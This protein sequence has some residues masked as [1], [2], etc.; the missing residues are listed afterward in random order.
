MKHKVEIFDIWQY[1]CGQLFN[2][3][4][5]IMCRIDF[6]GRIDVDILKQAIT[7]SQE[8]IP[9]IMY[10]FDGGSR[11]PRWVDHGY[12]VDD[13][14]RVETVGASAP[15]DAGAGADAVVKAGALANASDGAEALVHKHMTSHM[16]FSAGPQ[17]RVTIVKNARGG[18]ILCAT[19]SHILCDA[20]GFKQYLYLLCDLYTKLINGYELP[21]QKFARRGIKPLFAGMG[22][23]KIM[24]IMRSSFVHSKSPDDHIQGDLIH[25]DHIHD[26]HIQ[27]D[28]IQEGLDL[29]Q[30]KPGIF[31]MKRSISRN[32][33]KAFRSYLK[34]HGATVND[35]LMALITRAFCKNTDTSRLHIPATMDLRKFIP[36]NIEYGISNYSC[37]FICDVPIEAGDSPLNTI[38]HVSNQ[39]QKIKTTP[40]IL[41]TVLGLFIAVNMVSYTRLKTL[42]HRFTK[43]PNFL[44]TN[45]GVIDEEAM[46]FSDLQINDMYMT[47]GIK[48]RPYLLFT[49]STFKGQCTMGCNI[50]GSE[51]DEMFVERM[52]D[53]ICAEI[54]SLV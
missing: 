23:L 12:T 15:V 3:D 40:D 26:D 53:D 48:P 7:L 35:G 9:L 50:Q 25:D 17:L 1:L 38:T 34:T 24:K 21:Q 42:F 39:T 19:V 32:D 29:K 11:K 36:P 30:G 6:A 51:G 4:P 8:T 41:K 18:D 22:P 54:A 37:D 31:I 28:H 52:F 20:V 16:D 49:I 14:V 13:I 27:G 33:F 46:K 10:S 44:Y 47:T 45:F 43:M 5:L 2:Y